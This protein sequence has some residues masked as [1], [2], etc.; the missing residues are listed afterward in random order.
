MN[1]IDAGKSSLG[2]LAS[3]GSQTLADNS[4]WV[5]MLEQSQAVL[6]GRDAALKA[7]QGAAA[8]REITPQ[9]V[10]ATANVVKQMGKLAPGSL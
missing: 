2:F 10:A 8:V 4:A 7:Q 5:A 1:E 3:P 9:L 6:D